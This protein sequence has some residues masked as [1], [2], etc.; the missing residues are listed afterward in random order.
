M[1][2]TGHERD[3]NGAGGV[4]DDLD[5][6]HAR[7]C[8]PVTGRFL[9]FDAGQ[10]SLVRPQ[11]WNRYLY[12]AGNPLR[13][14]D[15]DG[16]E[17]MYA[18][19]NVEATFNAL[20]ARYPEVKASL[21]LYAGKD[22]PKLEISRGKVE[23]DPLT[24]EAINGTFTPKI[25]EE[26]AGNYEKMSGDADFAPNTGKFVSS[27]KLMSAA[28]VIDDALISGSRAEADVAV[29]EVAHAQQAAG[30]TKGYVVNSALDMVAPGGQALEHDKRPLEVDAI[31]FR[32]KVCGG[33]KQQCQSTSP[34]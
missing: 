15:R 30:D 22:D 17:I 19:K 9:S 23:K 13:F 33:E 32:N 18:T 6:M 8:S 7:F 14:V 5:Y 28:I 34:N 12:S 3:L 21:A 16:R 2:F 1:K 20:I 26:Y 10:S 24:G 31:K 11:S 29:H 25:R 4:G 27:A